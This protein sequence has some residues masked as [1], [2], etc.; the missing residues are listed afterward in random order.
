MMRR[1]LAV[2]ALAAACALLLV[3]NPAG[4]RNSTV[5]GS[6]ESTQP[7]IV[8]QQTDVLFVVDNSGSMREEQAGVAAELPAFVAALQQG[9]G[10][11]N[12]FQ[13]GVITTTVY[14]N[15]ISPPPVGQVLRTFPDQAGKL[16][17]AS[18]PDGG[19][20]RILAGTDPN[21]VP[22]F[23]T[24]IQ[25]GTTG[26]GQETPFEAVRLATSD[27]V[28]GRENAGFLR[29]G[30]RLV[31]VVVSDEDDCS[32]EVTFKADGGLTATPQ[33]AVSSSTNEDLCTQQSAKLGTI[34]QYYT[35]YNSLDNGNGAKRDV[36]WAAI[37]PVARTDKT[38]LAI[39]DNG[40][41][42]NIDCPTSNG[43]GYRH[44]AMA[45]K[46]NKQLA[47]LD[48]I[49]NPSYHDTLINIAALANITSSIAVR[50]MP[51]ARLV[52]VEITRADN[53]VQKCTID[54]GGLRYE[55]ATPTADARFY[56]LGPCPRLPDD[57]HVELK[58]LCAG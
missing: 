4:Q 49:C 58:M 12:D 33:V 40:T 19:T 1:T 6:C 27:P 28:V 53:T 32:E 26:S 13:V 3:C 22:V 50:G 55:E 11:E 47:N 8:P 17:P 14:Q 2:A 41:P 46:F 10:V 20:T 35:F 37:A 52:T 44:R 7:L 15:S 9:A 56:F 45:E 48:S 25:Q 36:L 18:L 51:D 30:A 31:V 57:K 34:D 23:A 21:L 16:R 39:D 5:P 38:A 29:K 42:R 43:P 54:N 24:L